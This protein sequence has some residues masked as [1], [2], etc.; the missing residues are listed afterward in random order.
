MLPVA[1]ATGYL[2]GGITGF[3]HGFS[4][5]L[6]VYLV[7]LAVTRWM[8]TTAPVRLVGERR[9]PDRDWRTLLDHEKCAYAR[10]LERDGFTEEARAIYQHLADRKYADPLPYERLASLCRNHGNTDAE[11]DVLQEAIRVLESDPDATRFT[12]PRRLR[13]LSD[14]LTELT[15][16]G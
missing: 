10:Q 7:A 3:F 2:L 16:T 13:A 4:L 11:V 15:S 6:L 12:A 5:A 1:S 14:R 9:R 8:R